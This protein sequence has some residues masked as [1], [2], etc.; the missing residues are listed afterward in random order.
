MEGK[1]FHHVVLRVKGFGT[2]L[3]CLAAQSKE[4]LR[5]SKKNNEFSVG[6]DSQDS[7]PWD[8]FLS[9]AVHFTPLGVSYPCCKECS[10][11]RQTAA[12]LLQ[13]AGGDII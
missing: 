5:Q 4:S 10:A 8:L 12:E 11:V 1:I 13:L 2:L 6:S 3:P 7:L 9:Q